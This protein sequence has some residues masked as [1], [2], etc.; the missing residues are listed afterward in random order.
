MSYPT[1]ADAAVRL[2]YRD[3]KDAC[4]VPDPP[5]RVSPPAAPSVGRAEGGPDVDWDDLATTLCADLSE[6]LEEGGEGEFESR[7]AILVHE[8][9][10]DHPALRDPDFWMWFA[11][12]PGR[13]VILQRY[14]PPKQP[15]KDSNKY[16]KNPLPAAENFFGS[17]AKETL[18]FRLWIR[19]EMAQSGEADDLYE[20]VR[21]GLVDFWRSHV[22]RQRY[23][24]HRPFLEALVD[25]QFPGDRSEARLG[26]EG[27]RTLAKELKI[28]CAN[29][30]VE[31][32]NR[33]Q[34]A[35]L[36]ERIHRDRVA[37]VSS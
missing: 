34:S 2:W 30:S 16:P 22:F 3:W 17:N 6:I 11:A 9:L 1:V 10:P 19:A 25:F 33:T 5:Q 36:I 15:P 4:L 27:V 14:V 7:G 12:H 8:T 13:D 37:G 32:L 21:P 28:V 18:F 29:I 20:F 23:T 26:T 31:A 35:A 24:R